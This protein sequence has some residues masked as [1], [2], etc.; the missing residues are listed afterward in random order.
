MEQV[1]KCFRKVRS[2]LERFFAP[3]I[4]RAGRIA[5]LI[6]AAAMGAAGILAFERVRWLAIVF[7]CAAALAFFEAARGWCV[8]RACGIKTK[9]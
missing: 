5:R 3:N 6:W 9:L 7:F 2:K 8:L 4:S 1:R